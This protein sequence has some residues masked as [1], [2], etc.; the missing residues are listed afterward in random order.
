[1]VFRTR[2]TI[3]RN[4]LSQSNIS[5]ERQNAS[6]QALRSYDIISGEQYSPLRCSYCMDEDTNASSSD[7]VL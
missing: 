2:N 6:P 1:M 7:K 3:I 4:G 5:H